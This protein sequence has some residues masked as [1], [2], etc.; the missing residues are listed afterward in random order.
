MFIYGA[1]GFLGLDYDMPVAVLGAI[2]LGIAVDFAIHFLER[3]RQIT[4]ETGSWD[5]TAPRMF[6][7]PA[8]AISRNVIIIAIGFLPMLVASLVPYKTTGLLLFS[9]LTISGIV[10]LLV[11][12]AILTVAQ[13]WLFRARRFRVQGEAGTPQAV[14]A[15]ALA[16]TGDPNHDPANDLGRQ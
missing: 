11:L 16:G 8:R 14:P 6:G 3:S 9:I 10:T 12:P 13:E 2:S 5:K 4:A 7:E 1:L 15:P